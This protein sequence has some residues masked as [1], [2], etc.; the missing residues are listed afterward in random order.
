[1]AECDTGDNLWLIRNKDGL[2]CMRGL[3]KATNTTESCNLLSFRF[4]S[5]FKDLS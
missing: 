2:F 5:P 3:Q 1:M 4:N